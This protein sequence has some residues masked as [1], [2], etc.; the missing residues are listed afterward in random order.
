M[1][2]RKSVQ[3]KLD[4]TKA[5]MAEKIGALSDRA[6]QVRSNLSIRDNMEK[7]PWVVL[8]GSVLVGIV[9]G[10]LMFARSTP[11]LAAAIANTAWL[12]A[13][14]PLKHAAEMLQH[15]GREAEDQIKTRTKQALNRIDHATDDAREALLSAV[16]RQ[17]REGSHAATT[18]PGR[19]ARSLRPV[20]PLAQTILLGLATAFLKQMFDGASGMSS[21]SS[22]G[23]ANAIPGNEAQENEAGS[24]A[25][26]F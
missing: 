22:N 10:R 14:G 21:K 19:I 9:F 5:N 25:T 7:R 6:E 13:A 1:D 15:K 2:N 8:G 26:D 16:K 4:Q 18:A 23:S 17:R 20:Q 12:S 3:E 11:R 24:A